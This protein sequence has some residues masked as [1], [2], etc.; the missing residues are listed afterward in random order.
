MYQSTQN[1]HFPLV[2]C[3]PDYN[4]GFAKIWTETQN[5]QFFNI[6]KIY[7]LYGETIE[8]NYF[9]TIWLM[10]YVWSTHMGYLKGG[11]EIIGL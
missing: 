10:E 9:L 7:T 5:F 8:N 2:N 1:Q 11:E 6:N 4:N 3:I